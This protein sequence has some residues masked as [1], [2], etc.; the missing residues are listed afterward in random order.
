M[1]QAQ[2]R[3]NAEAPGQGNEIS[4]KVAMA[5]EYEILLELGS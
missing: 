3:E 5:V 1:E 4:N 2:A